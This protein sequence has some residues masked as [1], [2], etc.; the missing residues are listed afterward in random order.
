MVPSSSYSQ[1]RLPAGGYAALPSASQGR[2]VREH[3]TFSSPSATALSAES[4]PSFFSMGHGNDKAIA[5]GTTTTTTA[6][7]SSSRMMM[8]VTNKGLFDANILGL[9]SDTFGVSSAPLSGQIATGTTVP[10]SPT[11]A[12]QTPASLNS[13]F[14]P[15]SPSVAA[16][17][18]AAT[19]KFTGL[20][21]SEI[22][23]HNGVPTFMGQDLRSHF[24]FG[25]STTSTTPTASTTVQGSSRSATSAIDPGTSLLSFDLLDELDGVSRSDLLYH[26]HALQQQHASL[27]GQISM[28]PNNGAQHTPL[29]ALGVDGGTAGPG[30]GGGNSLAF[31]QQQKEGQQPRTPPGFHDA[32]W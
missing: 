3:A 10:L 2:L 31:A 16:L 17:D 14:Q 13:L 32:V 24:L 12:L 6:P 9:A 11:T 18:S 25:D 26:Q 27:L 19:G 30:A 29:M 7:S 23:A 5:L 1:A 21:L 28:H 8:S 20:H 22:D 4:V 15:T